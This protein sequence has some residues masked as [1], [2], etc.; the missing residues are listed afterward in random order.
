MRPAAFRPWLQVTAEVAMIH[1]SPAVRVESSYLDWYAPPVA[2]V[3]SD[4]PGAASRREV[5]RKVSNNRN[6]QRPTARKVGTLLIPTVSRPHVRARATRAITV[7]VM[8]ESQESQSNHRLTNHS[9]SSS[10]PQTNRHMDM[11]AKLAAEIEEALGDMSVEDMLEVADKPRSSTETGQR[12][13]RTGTV[14]S[15]HGNDVFVEFG[16]K[17]QGVCPLSMF[18]S[19]PPLGARMEF[20]VERY[21]KE[22]GLLVLSRQG[23]VQKAEWELLEPGQVVEARCTGVN[24]G[25]LEL[26]VA[27]HKAFMPAGQVDLRHVADLSVFI[28]E[29]MPCEVIEIDRQRGRIIL[30]RRAALEQER[31]QLRTQ[32]LATL[33][34]G[35][36]LP[37]VI[38]SIQPYGAF[39]DLGGL[40]GL[41]HISDM[42]YE[43]IKHP[44][45]VVKE[46]QQV[47]VK[48]LKIDRKQDPPRISLGLKQTMED[49][50]TASLKAFE[51]G[52]TV[53]GRVTK[54]M[55][56]G[57]FVEIAPGVEG[58]IHISELSHD[59]V[60]DVR[61]VVRQEEIVT[62]KVL[63]IDPSSRRISLSLKALKSKEDHEAELQRKEDARMKKLRAQL[64]KKFGPLNLK[65]GIG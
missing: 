48:V 10:V 4:P 29:K 14:M 49:P 45:E 26:E 34:V 30:S 3:A 62:A 18:E 36:T 27:N 43:R 24:K 7:T 53:S 47:Q 21:D 28:G 35:Q 22:D 37:A 60:H 56:F 46:G 19:P 64:S 16:P 58:L 52:Q 51:E 17:S 20:I 55:P 38:I 11:D 12:Q 42:A 25:G 65:G 1:E 8:T 57:A 5:C 41:I 50:R 39:A 15:I 31:A 23:T 61:K 33:E 13:R 2:T 63:S 32:L 44:S 6:Y 40:D 9:Q 54:I 59:R